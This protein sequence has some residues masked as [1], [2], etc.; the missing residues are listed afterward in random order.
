MR[1]QHTES[2]EPIGLSL[3]EGASR[4]A[5]RAPR[6]GRLIGRYSGKGE[7]D[8]DVRRSAREEGSSVGIDQRAEHFVAGL[9]DF[10]ASL[11]LDLALGKFDDIGRH[12]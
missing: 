11:D 6:F 1:P 5:V 7:A 8:V 4:T 2:A 9:F 10:D 3:V 12:V